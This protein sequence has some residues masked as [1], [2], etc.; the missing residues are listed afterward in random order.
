MRRFWAIARLTAVESLRSRFV[1]VFA[2]VLAVSIVALA[3]G[4]EGD[5][6]L[7]GQLRAFLDYSVM[8]T[9]VL[10]G[11]LT[12]LLAAFVT[13]RDIQSKTVFTTAAKPVRAVVYVVGRWFGVTVVAGVL[14]AA[15]MASIYGLAHF[16]RQRPTEME[17]KKAQK[18]AG[19]EEPDSD[20]MRVD[21]DVFAARVEKAP[22][23]I[24]ADEQ[25][26]RWLQGLFEQEGKEEIIRQFLRLKLTRQAQSAGGAVPTDEQIDRLAA[27]PETRRRVEA[28]IRKQ[29]ADRIR[30]NAD[31]VEPGGVHEIRCSDVPPPPGRPI[32]LRYRLQAKMGQNAPESG[33]KSVWTIRKPTADGRVRLGVEP[34]DDSPDSASTL[35]IHP[36]LVTDDHRLLIAYRNRLENGTDVVLKDSQVRLRYMVGGFGGNVLRAGAII[37]VRIMFLAAAGVLC[38]TFVSFPVAC[39]VCLVLLLVGLMGDFSL[40]STRLGHFSQRGLT[41]YVSYGLARGAYSLLPKLPMLHSPSGNLRDGLKIVWNSGGGAA[42]GLLGANDDGRGAAWLCLRTVIVLAIAAALFRRRE[43]ARIQV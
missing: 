32:Q 33:L 39:L 31:V 21:N 40:D 4:V 18:E 35:L 22:D 19:P 41:D 43:L 5:G 9:Q 20:R 1:V 28:E 23:P 26:G 37:L 42:A 14:L 12:V 27:D 6:T 16:L 10:T 11:L 36:D 17:V 15:A 25:A 8:L 13:T 30:L 7:T 3:L 24:D 38:G 29:R 2:L 34:R